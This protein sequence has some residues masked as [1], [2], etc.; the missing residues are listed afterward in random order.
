MGSVAEEAELKWGPVSSTIKLRKSLKIQCPGT[1]GRTWRLAYQSQYLTHGRRQREGMEKILEEM[2]ENWFPEL[3][4]D[5]FC[6]CGSISSS[7]KWIQ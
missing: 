6:V 7:V 2:K 3:K 4:K 5:F 1:K